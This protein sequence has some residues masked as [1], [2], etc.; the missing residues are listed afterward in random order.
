MG[1]AIVGFLASVGT[2]GILALIVIFLIC[3]LF[4]MAWDVT[5]EKIEDV[6]H[7]RKVETKRT[8]KKASAISLFFKY[9]NGKIHGFCVTMDY[10]ER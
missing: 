2:I 1:M 6:W 5:V 8:P 10:D 7:Q 4:K 9:L 3:S